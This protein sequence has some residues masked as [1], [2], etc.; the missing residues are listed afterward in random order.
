M[1]QELLSAFH[2]EET[3]MELLRNLPKIAQLVNSRAKTQ[4]QAA[5][6]Q[7]LYP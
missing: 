5:W 1:M 3:S 2:D 4:T 7:N 6:L